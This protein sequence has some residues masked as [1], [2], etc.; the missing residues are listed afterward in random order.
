MRMPFASHKECEK[1][2][3]AH[4]KNENEFTIGFLTT[5][6]SVYEDFALEFDQDF[7]RG[8]YISWDFL[9]TNRSLCL[10]GRFAHQYL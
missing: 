8:A 2:G 7:N 3:L 10:T 4:T 9:E 1:R 5:G 6:S